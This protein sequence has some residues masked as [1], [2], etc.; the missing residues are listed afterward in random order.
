MQETKRQ[1]TRAEIPSQYKWD[2]TEL[3]ATVED[4]EGAIREV[5]ELIP[6][7]K[8]YQGRLSASAQNLLEALRLSDEI[9]QRTRRIVAYARLN[10]DTDT[11]NQTFQGLDGR[12]TELATR[13]GTAA[14]F[15]RPEILAI[16]DD[17]LEGF[18]T[19]NDE[20]KVYDHALKE[21]RRQKDHVL[22][23]EVES[24]LS[25]VSEVAQAPQ[26]VFTM[27]NNADIKFPTVKDE[28]GEEVELTH[29][30]YSRLIKSKNRE[31]RKAAFKALYSTYK[32]QQNTIAALLNASVKKDVFYARVRKY[33]SALEYSLDNYNIPVSVYDNLTETVRKNLHLMHRYVSLR[34]KALGV[35]ELHMY[36]VYTPLVQDVDFH[37]P[38]EEA[39]RLVVEGLAPLGP[40]YVRQ[41]QE[42]M[43]NRWLDVYESAGKRS[44]AYSYGIFGHHP[45]VLLNHQDNLDSAFTLAHEMGHAM[46]SHYSTTTQPY[47]YAGYTI[48]LAEVASTVNESLLMN[49]LLN[50]TENK[51][52][53]LY[54]INH[55]LDEF[56]GTVF[57]QTMFAEFERWTHE[58][59]EK[60]TTLT[61]ALMND[62]YRQ[63]NEDYHGPDMIIDPEIHLEWARIPHFYRAF[64]VYQYATGFSA[65]TA[66]SQ[67]ILNEGQPAVDRYL[68]FL[69]SGS[70]DYSLNLLK[71]AGVDMTKPDPIQAG[72]DL[73]AKLLDEMEQLLA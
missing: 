62:F 41:L 17:T 73:F 2:L 32:K 72:M 51:A 22:S 21:L 52:K 43:D 26:T 46:H 53:R 31:V 39:K 35:D 61:S 10:M 30:R 29:A 33:N 55:Y 56:R 67:Q 44:G 16:A 13:V 11:T 34:K 38:F 68:E 12:A 37:I 71:K 9:S 48:F 4:W 5:E 24:I 57:R 66:L 23:T 14:S 19:E 18:L 47:V 45:Y 63:L 49:H 15:M 3:Y 8:A 27:V 1:R 70:S 7:L 59:V 58:T 54:L 6:R 25:Q 28:D 36:D 65:A 50:T 20:L 40:D 42:G 60:G 64:Y 69:S